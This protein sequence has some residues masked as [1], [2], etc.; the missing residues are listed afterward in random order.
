M[1]L[2]LEPAKKWIFGLLSLSI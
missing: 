1:I 2:E